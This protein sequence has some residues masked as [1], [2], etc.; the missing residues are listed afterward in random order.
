MFFSTFFFGGGLFF[1]A[2]PGQLF[3]NKD[4]LPHKLDIKRVGFHLLY[5]FKLE[6]KL[7]KRSSNHIISVI[8]TKFTKKHLNIFNAKKI[9]SDS[10]KA[11]QAEL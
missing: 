9:V 5:H 11:C 2:S 6:H 4:L 8:V 3:C 7:M 10:S 1:Y